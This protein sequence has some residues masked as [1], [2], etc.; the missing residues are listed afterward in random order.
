M[1]FDKT[2]IGVDFGSDA[3]KAV[4]IRIAGG[5]AAIERSLVLRREDLEEA[6]SGPDGIAALARR[7]RKEMQAAGFRGQAIVLG[8]DGS[9]SIL[10]Y[11]QAPPMPASR[12]GL[13]LQYEV[14]SVGERMGEVLA[15]D[16]RVLPTMRDDGEQTV[17]L[18]LAKEGPLSELLDALQGAGFSITA[19]VPAPLALF[20]AWDLFG[21]KADL[22]SPD[23]DVVLAVDVGEKTLD[24]AV[25]LNNRLVF[26][27]TSSFGGAQFTEA[28]EREFNASTEKAEKLKLMRGGLDESLANVDHRVVSV[29]R[30]PGG[31]LLGTLQ[32]TLRL[33]SGQAG[34]RLPP[35]TRVWLT[36]GGV[37]LRGLAAYLGKALG[38][39]DVE[40]FEP[41][42]GG[43]NSL[44]LALGLCGVGLQKPHAGD[45][46]VY[47]N[48]L[49]QKYVQK[50]TFR[51]RT[52][53][54]WV[55]GILLGVLL[56]AQLAHGFV[57]NRIA[58]EAYQN[59]EDRHNTLLLQKSE[60]DDWSARSQQAKQRLQ[61]LLKE[62]ELTSFQSYLVDWL[63]R[64]LRPEI[65]IET[66]DMELREALP[67][68][69]AA[70]DFTAIDYVVVLEGRVDNKTQRAIDW[71]Q[72]LEAELKQADLVRDVSYAPREE[73]GGFFLFELVVSPASAGL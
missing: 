37:R 69:D 22:D 66:L 8:I 5:G 29:L 44:A 26:A 15:S 65:Q 43:K 42:G 20:G 10:R 23:D 46:G 25:I 50:R 53:Y 52:R 51:E 68:A 62:A 59:L 6:E 57:R 9:E 11:N 39:V 2:M 72:E 55:A 63:G 67:A 30:T 7:L 27:R 35:L 17:L 58:D 64:S 3:I 61:R 73:S 71:I 48:I 19:A 60:R 40:T 38:G 33:A 34:L 47:L 32:S 18:G 56:I 28:L 36:G 31:Q 1:A 70:D 4:E 41:D 13:I 54:L 24:A 16:F 49:P 45:G 12:L 21:D 14:E